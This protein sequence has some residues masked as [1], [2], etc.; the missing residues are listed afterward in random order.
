M[1]EIDPAIPTAFYEGN[2]VDLDLARREKGV[3]AIAG[4]ADHLAC[5][6]DGV[7]LCDREMW[8]IGPRLAVLQC[9]SIAQIMQL[10]HAVGTVGYSNENRRSGR[11][12]SLDITQGNLEGSGRAADFRQLIDRLLLGTGQTSGR[13]HREVGISMGVRW[14]K[15]ATQLFDK[16][17]DRI[18]HIRNRGVHDASHEGFIIPGRR[19]CAVCQA[20]ELQQDGSF[21]QP[22]MLTVVFLS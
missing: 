21:D 16:G 19:G 7:H 11:D 6:I 3:P 18:A 20:G 4:N 22:L 14:V 12:E 13:Q 2:R 10:P 15:I 17:A 1:G 5:L 8:H 9:R